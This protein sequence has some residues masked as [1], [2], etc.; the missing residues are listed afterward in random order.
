M[1]NIIEEYF[2]PKELAK[3]WKMSISFIRKEIREGRL[4]F[5]PCGRCV[6]IPK[7]YVIEYIENYMNRR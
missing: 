4:K 2:T 1:N 5:K 6:R 7:E 3:M